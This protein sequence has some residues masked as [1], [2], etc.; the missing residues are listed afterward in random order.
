MLRDRPDFHLAVLWML[1]DRPD[2]HH[3]AELRVRDRPY[4]QGRAV[5]LLRRLVELGMRAGEAFADHRLLNRVIELGLAY[6]PEVSLGVWLHLRP[7]PRAAHGD[8]PA[9]N[10]HEVGVR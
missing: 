2:F 3:V 4:A 6:S 5:V 7:T 9:L 1:R 8:D 10:A